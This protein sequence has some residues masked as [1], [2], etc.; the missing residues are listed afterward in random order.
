MMSLGVLIC[1]AHRKNRQ[2]TGIKGSTRPS[3][4]N[5]HKEI[6]MHTVTVPAARRQT[7]TPRRPSPLVRVVNWELRRVLASRL[8]W[9][10]ALCFFALMLYWVW[11]GRESR[12][13]TPTTPPVIVAGTSAWGLMFFLPNGLGLLG[14]LM[15]FV[16][17]DGVARDLHRR[18]HELV[19]TTALPGWAYVWGRYVAGLTMGLGLAVVMLAAI[20]GEGVFLHLTI[21]DYPVPDIGNVLILWGGL[22]VSATIL[23]SSVSFALGTQFPRQSLLSKIG[24]VL[25]WFLGTFILPGEMGLTFVTKP[26]AWYSAWDPTSVAT[27]FDGISQFTV[28]FQN[29][30]AHLTSA[31]QA[32]HLVLSLENTMPDLAGWF[33]PHLLVAGLSLLLVMLAVFGFQ[34][35]RNTFGG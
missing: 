26:P 21:P 14:L 20:L 1:H 22:V 33:T 32:Q 6:R 12:F 4:T 8:F 28:E 25:A 23:L 24:I 17:A 7:L 27:A 30:T 3:A 5:N 29:Q 2:A 19:M 11:V 31:A 34:R 35:F 16:T 13:M 10:Q 15:P 18:T 9:V